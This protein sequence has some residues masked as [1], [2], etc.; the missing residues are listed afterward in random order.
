M[1][2]WNK[3]CAEEDQNRYPNILTTSKAKMLLPD[4]AAR[5]PTKTIPISLLSGM[6]WIGSSL[7]FSYL[8]P[9]DIVEQAKRGPVLFSCEKADNELGM[10]DQY[11]SIDESVKK[12]IISARKLIMEELN[13]SVI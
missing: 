8:L 5:C 1:E 2:S 6:S 7:G 10:G 9:P 4:N 11:T 3:I 12:G 13:I